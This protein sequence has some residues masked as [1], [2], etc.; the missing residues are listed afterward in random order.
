MFT[1]AVPRV[2]IQALMVSYEAISYPLLSCKTLPVS[3][4]YA[5]LAAAPVNMNRFFWGDP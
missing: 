2:D 4:A 1:R 5:I 3:V